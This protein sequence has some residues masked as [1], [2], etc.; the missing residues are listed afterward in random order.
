[1]TAKNGAV[2][3]AAAPKRIVSLS[4]TATEDLAAVGAQAQVVAVDDQ[5]DFP[6]AMP[7]TALSGYK[8]DVEAISKYNPDLVIVSYDANQI[9]EQLTKL[10]VPVLFFDAAS[11]LDDSYSQITGIGAATGHAAEAATEVTT[12]KSAIAAAVAGARK[13]ATPLKYYY[14]VGTAPYYSST[15]KTFIGS[16]FAQFGVTN[17]ADAADKTGSG[18][19]QLSDEY[20]VSS[21]PDLIFLAD[22]K[23]CQQS[24][25]TVS[26]RPGWATV[27][28]V[29]NS[30]AKGTVVMLDDDVASRW[31]PRL[32]DLVQQISAAVTK[33][34]G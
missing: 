20:I 25:A 29:R 13:P 2:K 19:P 21:A 22:T 17:V 7:K 34:Q 1:V 27:P 8:P 11:S 30:A 31:G 23:C 18:Y 10:G 9:V 33:A 32:V 28:A 5:S 24:A 16:I 12:M 6:A 3:I 14:E 15:S 4:A 26:A